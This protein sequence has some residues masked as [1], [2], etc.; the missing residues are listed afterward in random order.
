[1]INCQ[2]TS[3]YFLLVC[4]KCYAVSLSGHLPAM[5]LSGHPPTPP[6]S[7]LTIQFLTMMMKLGYIRGTIPDLIK[8]TQHNVQYTLTTLMGNIYLEY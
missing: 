3:S 5:S 1:M 8:L 6:L 7:R 2:G 4:M